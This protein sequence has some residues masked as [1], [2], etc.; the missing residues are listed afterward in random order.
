MRNFDIASHTNITARAFSTLHPDHIM[1]LTP[2]FTEADPTV[3]LSDPKD[4]RR[5]SDLYKA[6]REAERSHWIL[7]QS[8]E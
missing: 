3:S 8:S 4:S 5:T 2:T 6:E 1:H 7:E